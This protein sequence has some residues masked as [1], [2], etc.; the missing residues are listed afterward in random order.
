MAMKINLSIFNRPEGRILSAIS[1]FLALNMALLAN[2]KSQYSFFSIAQNPDVFYLFFFLLLATT[3]ATLFFFSRKTNL[4]SSIK[5]IFFTL[6]P[7]ELTLL[8]SLHFWKPELSVLFFLFAGIY[9]FIAIFAILKKLEP[10]EQ[11]K[12]SRKQ[13][14]KEWIKSQ[15]AATLV[16]LFLIT[17]LSG[18]FGSYKIAQFSAVDEALWTFDRIPSFWKNISDQDWNDTNISD[19]PGITVALISGI[20]L[21]DTNPKLFNPKVKGSKNLD[22]LT[23]N[24][25]F[26]LPILLFTV[27]LLP[28]FYFLL[29][30]LL[31]KRTALL[32]V[33]FIG[34]SPAL[35]GMSRII[36]PDA[37]LWVFAPLAI[38]SFLVYQKRKLA[39]YLYLAGIFLGLAILTKYVANILYVFFLGMIF[40]EYIFNFQRYENIAASKYLRSAIINFAI[41]V[42]T[43]LATF[44]LLY[45]GTW[46]KP[47]RIFKGTILSQAFVST[48]PIFAIFFL[49]LIADTVLFKNKLTGWVLNFL[50]KKRHLLAMLFSAVLLAAIA[51]LFVDVYTGMKP[52]NFEEILASPK[53]SYKENGFIGLLLSNFYPL[54]FAITPLAVLGLLTVLIRMLIWRKSDKDMEKRSIAVFFI[55]FI[56]LYYFGTTINNVVSTTR[57]QIMLYPLVLIISSIGLSFLFEFVSQRFAWKKY[58]FHAFVLLVVLISASSLIYSPFY[59]SYASALL[60]QK[61]Y[62]DLKDMGPGS[63]EAAQYLNSLPNAEKLA[64]W[65]DKKGVCTFFKGAC[66]GDFSYNELEDVSLDYVVVSWGRK[67]RTTNM[68][69]GRFKLSSHAIF[70]FAKY[71]DQEDNIAYKL[72][73]NDRPAQYI[74][75]IKVK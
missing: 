42:L 16:L 41:L 33:S 68:V 63:Y 23:L 19:K 65:T 24:S 8:A 46:L 21:M 12:T 53:T 27:L 54:L 66:Y 52:Y 38:L 49:L 22:V 18:I 29:E 6:I 34:L 39:E 14:A 13:A 15:G 67:T 64:I 3:L 44:Y 4:A 57:Y 36:N 20:G 30:R 9:G 71:Y 43:S 45:P 70:N 2:R 10:I 40:L 55:I 11:E 69:K 1:F 35:I 59:L 17:L 56:F 26:R 60:P 47:E 51:F 37:L 61:N 7:F 25:K 73:I 32:S 5:K 62:L 72:L 31:G 75:V 48:W 74:K 28:L 58:S 50:S